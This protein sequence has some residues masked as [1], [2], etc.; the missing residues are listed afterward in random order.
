MFVGFLLGLPVILSHDLSQAQLELQKFVHEGEERAIS[1][2]PNVH[3]GVALLREGGQGA[4]DGF[5]VVREG[6]VFPL[7][8]PRDNFG[9]LR[10]KRERERGENIA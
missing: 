2:E 5:D 4:G 3:G 6:V 7:S 9:Q 8:V 1:G 10:L